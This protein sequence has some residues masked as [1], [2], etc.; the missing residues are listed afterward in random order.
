MNSVKNSVN[1]TRWF[2]TSS[3]KKSDKKAS[4]ELKYSI[5]VMYLTFLV[6]SEHQTALYEIAT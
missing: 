1:F 6:V 2:S 3:V 4:V 5:C